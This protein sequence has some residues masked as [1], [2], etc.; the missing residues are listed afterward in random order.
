MVELQLSNDLRKLIGIVYSIKFPVSERYILEPQIKRAVISSSLNVREGNTFYEKKN[1]A[2]FFKI[3]LGSLTE[4]EECIKISKELNYININ[5]IDTFYA[6]Y[7]LCLNKLKK[8][9]NSLN[10]GD[11]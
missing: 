6:Q 11:K 10:S 3:A 1:K 4:T 8:L 5:F 2:R 9:I 7:W